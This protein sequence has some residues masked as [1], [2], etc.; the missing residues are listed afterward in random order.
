MRSIGIAAAAASLLVLG[1]VAIA[2]CGGSDDTSSTTAAISEDDFVTQANAICAEGNKTL[3]AAGQEAFSGKPS[4]AE[5]DQYVTDTMVPNIQGQIDEI[6]AL[7]APAGDEEQVS[8]FLD[9]AQETLDQVEADPSV[10]TSGDQDA[11]AE[12]NE[13]MTDYGLTEC[14]G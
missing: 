9:T 7:G 11:F 5:L 1:A 4:E 3:E 14:A 10:L 12:T 13:L 6:T 8:G 2:G